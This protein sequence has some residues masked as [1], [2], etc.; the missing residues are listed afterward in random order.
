MRNPSLSSWLH[1][2]RFI[3][4]D[5]DPRFDFGSAGNAGT[6]LEPEDLAR[7]APN[8]LQLE[9]LRA[10]AVKRSDPLSILHIEGG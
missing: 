3:E 5:P 1:A 4:R 2:R 8:R 10:L 9:V 6:L 7:G